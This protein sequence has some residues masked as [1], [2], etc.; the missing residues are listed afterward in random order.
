MSRKQDVWKQILDQSSCLVMEKYFGERNCTA[1]SSIWTLNC[2]SFI[3]A[4][5]WLPVRRF[6]LAPCIWIT[7]LSAFIFTMSFSEHPFDK[8][9]SDWLMNQS[10]QATFTEYLP[11]VGHS[12]G[13]AKMWVS[14]G[15]YTLKNHYPFDKETETQ[16]EVKWLTPRVLGLSVGARSRTISFNFL[17]WVLP[18]QPAAH[19]AV[20]GGVGLT[21][22]FFLVCFLSVSWAS[23]GRSF[24]VFQLWHVRLHSKST[25]L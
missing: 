22:G 15:L 9:E 13:M 8:I 23:L 2:L 5:N 3:I 4:N 14:W 20:F 17:I 6:Q 10:D 21:L 12:W 7:L 19:F 24:C 1:S 16:S 18:L 25:D 11:W